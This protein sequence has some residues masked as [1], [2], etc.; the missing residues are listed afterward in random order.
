MGNA[1]RQELA[2][3]GTLI[4]SVH[5]GAADTDMM[6]GFDVP[7]SD[8]AAVARAAL[9]GVESGAYEVV[10]DEFTAM[11]KASLSRDPSEFESRF[12]E[13][14]RASRTDGTPF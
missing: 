5:L 7:K 11:V 4:T 13:L 8:P 14:R 1:L 3:Q 2:G 12:R 6:K 9:D 10:V